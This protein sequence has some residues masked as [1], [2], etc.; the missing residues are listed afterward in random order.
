MTKY[1]LFPV[2]GILLLV[3]CEKVT[4]E[5]L[6]AGF[7]SDKDFQLHME[8]IALERDKALKELILYATNLE[9]MNRD[10]QYEIAVGQLKKGQ[11]KYISQGG[12]TIK[13]IVAS[14]AILNLKDE[15]DSVKE[16]Q[17][18]SKDRAIDCLMD[19][20][21]D[22]SDWEEGSA[23]Y[24]IMKASYDMKTLLCQMKMYDAESLS[25]TFLR[26]HSAARVLANSEQVFS[27]KED[28]SIFL[29]DNL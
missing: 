3:G 28:A 21:M 18:V 12:N 26:I 27:T 22:L 1:L 16:S 29:N 9:N 23:S 2:F 11:R 10:N 19:I 17:E 20:D 25:N 15:F 24:N 4:D 5:A 13:L 8:K 6:N 7:K 14:D